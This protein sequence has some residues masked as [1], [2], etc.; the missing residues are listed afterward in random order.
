MEPLNWGDWN[1]P[2]Y[3]D[4][5]KGCDAWGNLEYDLP[6]VLGLGWVA[7][8]R[9]PMWDAFVAAAEHYRDVDIIHHDP[10]HP[11][12]VGLNHPHKVGHFAAEAI[13]NVDLGHVWLEGLL[14]HYRLTGER[15]SLE[16]ARAM[17]D[18]LAGRVGKAGNPRQFGWP[19]IA[20]AALA[21]ATGDARYR[22][23]ATHFA[24]PALRAYEPT[25]AA[26][27]W[28]IGI[29]ADGLAAV[30]SVAPDPARLGWLRAYADALVGAPPDRF[31]DARYALPL[32]LLAVWLHDARYHERALS[33]AGDLEIGDWGKTLA[34]AGRTG[35][36]LLG[37]LAT[38]SDSRSTATP[39]PAAPRPQ[40]AP[41][42]RRR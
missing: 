36:R 19:M 15:R 3:R 28:K 2:G 29:L 5:T 24:E 25:P 42:R 37:P 16:A 8:G 30:Q 20:L 1:F 11:D 13:Q 41:A 34:L 23:A 31:A 7:T 6:Q 17:G 32:G 4:R 14:T 21:D 26:A 27:D 9:R 12:R 18:A 39:V 35:F 22:E 38:R 33:V 10:D 40:S